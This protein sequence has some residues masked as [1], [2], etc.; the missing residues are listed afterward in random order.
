MI[1]R[2]EERLLPACL[3]SVKGVVDEVVLIDTGST[4][5]T[6]RIAVEGGARVY[7]QPWHDDFAAPRNE[8]LAHALGEYVLQLDA[9]ERL[10]PGAG[11]ALHALL[12]RG[13]F[14]VGFLRLHNAS[15]AD[16]TA[17]EVLSGGARQG[18]PVLL[19]RLIRI[20]EGLRYSGI[21]HES[22]EESL[23]GKRARALRVDAD[24]VHLGAA[25]ELRGGEAKRARNLALLRRRC[26]LEPDSTT[27]FGYLAMELLEGGTIAE[28]EA[29]AEEGWTKV[30]AQP[31]YRSI[32]L[33]AVARAMTALKMGKGG[34][35]LETTGRALAR[36]P[37]SADLQFLR[38]CGLELQALA[39][40][41]GDPR[42]CVILDEA[43]G[44]YRLAVAC[45]AGED[46]QTYVDGAHSWAGWTR[47]ATV[48]L[49]QD[50]WSD[51]RSAFSAALVARPG[52]T[53]ALLGQAEVRV[54]TGDFRG[55]FWILEPLLDVA[56]DGW[57][58]AAAA[59]RGCGFMTDA[60]LFFS[61]ACNRARKGYLSPHR[62]ERHRAL[63]ALLA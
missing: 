48:L 5:S 26:A 2:N 16:A 27:P 56:P 45:Q 63:S 37:V 50:Q 20:V 25:P 43:A 57:L 3:Q 6:R 29:V 55:A 1:A 10:V 53:E 34:C 12:G 52:H 38:G 14:E 19:P 7:E 54:E 33:L 24:I 11:E 18:Y 23:V 17:R 58:L 41:N 4:D 35:I 44:A 47:L 31:S 30:D 61:R 21:V 9:D 39:L 42:R 40:P 59:A 62:K 60:Q 22:I 46:G 28:A 49:L 13:G 15:R 8:A 51:A 36:V 32:H